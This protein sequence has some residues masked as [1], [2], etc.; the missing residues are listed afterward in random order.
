MK[1]VKI[2]YFS[3]IKDISLIQQLQLIALFAQVRQKIRQDGNILRYSTFFPLKYFF[4]PVLIDYTPRCNT[5]EFL[6]DIEYF[7]QTAYNTVISR[8]ENCAYETDEIRFCKSQMDPERRYGCRNDSA[9]YFIPVLIRNTP[10]VH[11][12]S[13]K[14]GLRAGALLL[15][16]LPLFGLI[17]QK[18]NS[19]EDNEIHTDNAAERIQIEQEREAE[20]FKSQLLISALGF[21][22][23]FLGITAAICMG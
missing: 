12:G 1:K 20:S 3:I 2:S 5:A 21:I 23:A 9:A 15:V 7:E 22:G 14:Y 17:P 19:W 8:K 18:R 6:S 4:L 10:A 11:V 16:L 13:G